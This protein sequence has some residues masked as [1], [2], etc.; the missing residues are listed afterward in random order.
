MLFNKGLFMAS[1]DLSNPL[2]SQASPVLS[3]TPSSDSKDSSPS[4]E[5]FKDMISEK[6]SK[7]CIESL[8]EKTFKIIFDK[9][10]SFADQV[11][12]TLVDIAKYPR[13]REFLLTLG[14]KLQEIGKPLEFHEGP[15]TRA[16]VTKAGNFVMSVNFESMDCERTLFEDSQGHWHLRSL[17]PSRYLAH[18]LTHIFHYALNLTSA[19]TKIG[20]KSLQWSND[21]EQDTIEGIGK[22]EFTENIYA[23]ERGED[24]RIA[25]T[26]FDVDRRLK[27]SGPFIYRSIQ[28]GADGDISKC[29][30]TLNFVCEQY[31]KLPFERIEA[32]KKSDLLFLDKLAEH[33]INAL[34]LL[35]K[36]YSSEQREG[37]LKDIIHSGITKVDEIDGNQELEAFYKKLVTG[38]HSLSS[39]TSSL[40]FRT[41]RC[42]FPCKINPLSFLKSFW[43]GMKR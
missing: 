26:G 27:D 4:R 29:D 41:K 9:D 21:E 11:Y 18:E 31:L 17:S 8:M 22:A 10:K 6:D 23:M 35:L 38:A 5:I 2:S 19:K 39:N 36:D 7:Q 13:A 12:N 14:K 33:K 1:I 42:N 3:L 20:S 34:R 30:K 24:C 15:D 32:I 43:S 28:F 37:L 40:K 25:H 16:L